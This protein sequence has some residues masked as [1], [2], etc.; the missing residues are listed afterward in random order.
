MKTYKIFEILEEDFDEL[1]GGMV[2]AI[3]DGKTVFYVGMSNRCVAQRIVSHFGV[4][5]S[6]VGN[7][8]ARWVYEDNAPDSSNWE[9]DFYFFDD[10]KPLVK[11]HFPMFRNWDNA[12]AEIAIIHELRPCLNRH[13][14]P[15][16]RRLPEKYR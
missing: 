12:T 6:M 14:N 5:P 13:H 8:L 7:S 4:Y 15:N 16:G 1:E 9:V 3:R 11:K 2:Y 10:C